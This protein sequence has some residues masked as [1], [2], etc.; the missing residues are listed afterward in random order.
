MAAAPPAGDSS[1]HL[2]GTNGTSPPEASQ[3]K[4]APEAPSTSATTGQPAGMPATE[5]ATEQGSEEHAALSFR[6]HMWDSFEFLWQKRIEPSRKLTEDFVVVLRERAQ[7]ERQYAKSLARSAARLQSH[8][9]LGNMPEACEAVMVNMRNRAEQSLELASGIEQDV[10]ETIEAMLRQHSEVSKQVRA[11]GSRVSKSFQEARKSHEDVAGKYAQACVVA[12]DSAK[13]YK[14][15]VFLSLPHNER[16]RRAARMMTLSRQATAMERGY[17]TAVNRLNE[18]TRLHERQMGHVLGALQD[19]EE[20]RANCFKDS[21]MKMAVFDVSWLRNMQYD[22]EGAVKGIEDGD[23]VADVQKYIKQHQTAAPRPSLVRQQSYWEIA[24][25]IQGLASRST[26]ARDSQKEAEANLDRHAEALRPLVRSLLQ[27]AE[28]A[29]A[30]AADADKVA[31]LK[32]G[33]EGTESSENSSGGASSTSAL[34][35]QAFCTAFQKELLLQAV[36]AN[37]E[38]YAARIEDMPPI[39]VGAASFDIF[40]TLVRAAL[41]GCHNEGDAWSGRTLMVLCNKIQ[42]VQEGKVV[43]ILVRVY[44]H[45]LWGR[46]TFWEEMLY[47]AICEAQAQLHERRRSSPPGT[48]FPEVVITPFLQN[49]MRFMVSWGIQPQQAQA[50]VQRTCRKY[51]G[52]S[53]GSPMAEA[54]IEHLLRRPDGAAGSAAKDASSPPTATAA[55]AA[56]PGKS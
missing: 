12:E 5:T 56:A 47:V 33:L 20:K 37:N 6:E 2:A 34:C 3:S 46:V 50:C 4:V 55:P 10:V 39:Q 29:P 17:F 8:A 11:D 15:S 44:N 19:M 43:D 38:D 16:M 27:H 30:G 18:A 9:D 13:E 1:V 54:Y 22:L 35:R 41:D 31:E 23:G 49:F 21:A 14:S 7:L 53:A 26:T 40:V 48:E 51:I 25:T 45:P 42:N 28:S 52:N 24:A 32:K 36:K